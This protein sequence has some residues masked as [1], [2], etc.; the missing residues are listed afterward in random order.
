MVEQ[1]LPSAPFDFSK[2]LQR[3][4]SRQSQIHFIDA[5]TSTFS[6]VFQL[7]SHY[8][9]MTISSVG[10]PDQPILQLTYPDNLSQQT[11][12][13]LRSSIQKMFSTEINLLPFY[14][15]MSNDEHWQIL[16]TQFY[17][18]RPIQDANL[19]ESMI[20]IIIG[21]QL[22]TKFAATLV[23][24]LIDLGGE[25]IYWNDMNM[26]V[27][28]S[29]EKVANWSYAQLRAHAFS[30]RKAEYII[31]FARAVV[32]G[33]IDLEDLWQMKD[34]EIFEKL[35][36]LRGIG[37][38]TVEC[39]LLFGLGRPDFIPAADIGI[40]NAIQKLYGLPTRPKEKEIRHLS[41]SWSP[42]RSYATYYLWQSLTPIT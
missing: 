31:D 18:L 12:A 8:I 34:E 14:Q 21:Q 7:K 29:P 20:K 27:F 26:P 9:P 24:R 10:T 41:E 19:F 40:Q 36:L 2:M 11:R 39:F 17:G 4:L 28:P 6:R 30:Q 23:E 1:Y 32:N 16:I 3:S 22:N 25:F 33:S 15:Q 13:E 42:W 37:R 5:E 38:W 35:I